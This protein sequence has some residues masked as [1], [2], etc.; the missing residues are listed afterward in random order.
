[1][2]I[3]DLQRCIEKIHLQMEALSPG[4][5]DEFFLAIQAVEQENPEARNRK[6]I[7][8]W[9]AQIFFNACGENG[10]LVTP[11]TSIVDAFRR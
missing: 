3:D 1:M 2:S 6:A 7:A 9:S 5:V 11:K 4:A 10:H 8:E